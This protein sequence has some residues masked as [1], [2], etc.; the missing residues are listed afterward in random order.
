MTIYWIE[1]DFWSWKSST[2]VY[3][4]RKI[5]RK[6]PNAFI[7][8]NIKI[9]E[10]RF[11]NYCYFEDEKFADTLRALNAFNDIEREEY[12]QSIAWRTLKRYYRKK[13]T[14]MYLLFDESWAVMNN[15][16]HKDEDKRLPEYVNQNRKMFTDIYCITADGDQNAKTLRRFIERYIQPEKIKFPILEDFALVYKVKKD[17]EWNIV[18]KQFLA[19]DDNGDYI[20]KHKPE[21]YFDDFYYKPLVRSLYDD[22]H[23]N[24]RD[25]DKYKKVNYSLLKNILSKKPKVKSILD[26]SK[27]EDFKILK[28]NLASE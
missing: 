7:I 15:K 13:F 6:D 24:I 21:R 16:E 11:K 28:D 1:G 8:S 27:N 9:E 10:S 12:T 14:K 2:A 18:Q 17:K 4:A 19:K 3:L 22:L 23:K 20:T 5:T 26:K 25:P